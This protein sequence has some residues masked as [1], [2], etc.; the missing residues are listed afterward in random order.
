MFKSIICICVY[1]EK[2]YGGI[3]VTCNEDCVL[4]WVSFISLI[5]ATLF[6]IMVRDGNN[7]M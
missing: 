5:R 3:L 4:K 7:G 2:I 1:G 6:W